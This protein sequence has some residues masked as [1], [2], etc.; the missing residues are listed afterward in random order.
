MIYQFG[1]KNMDGLRPSAPLPVPDLI[2]LFETQRMVNAANSNHMSMQIEK[3]NE[4]LNALLMLISRK[5][6]G[7]TY[8]RGNVLDIQ[9]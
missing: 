4:D 8:K 9:S 1:G 3:M 7:G 6:G 2:S 5:G